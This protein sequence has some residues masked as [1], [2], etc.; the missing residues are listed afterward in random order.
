M[1]PRI[2]IL[3]HSLPDELSALKIEAAVID[4]IGKDNLTNEVR[5]YETGVFGCTPPDEFIAI[6]EAQPVEIEEPAI[7]SRGGAALVV[8][9]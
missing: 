1:E 9:K 5:G 6:F 7:R 8:K 4:L 2:E 3:V